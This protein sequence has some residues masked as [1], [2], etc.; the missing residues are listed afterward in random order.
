MTGLRSGSRPW[1]DGTD[2]SASPPSN[3]IR[4]P[5]SVDI[6]GAGGGPERRPPTVEAGRRRG[7]VRARAESRDP[8]GPGDAERVPGRHTS[9][10]IDPG[11]P[12]SLAGRCR[13][14]CQLRPA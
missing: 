6:G 3:E 11:L 14:V 5:G 10:V 2:P 8:P 9:G 12:L 1:C 13:V 7:V 4:G